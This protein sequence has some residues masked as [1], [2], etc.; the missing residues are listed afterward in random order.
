MSIVLRKDDFVC[1]SIWGYLLE[2][3]N[4]ETY[5]VIGGKVVDREIEELD[6][7]PI[8]SIGEKL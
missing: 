8:K 1:A 2:A 4:I 7:T 5:E 3:A 6:F